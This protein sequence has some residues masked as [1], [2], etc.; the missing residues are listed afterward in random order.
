MNE[1][2]PDAARGAVSLTEVLRAA[3]AEGFRAEFD[4]ETAAAEG[5]PDG[6]RCSDCGGTS[7]AADV[8]RL[9]TRRLEGASDPADMLHV[10]GLRCPRCS[11]LGVLISPYGANIDPA[12]VEILR[13]LPPPVG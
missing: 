10:S 6:L 12:H 9:W 1:T 11:A 7:D 13:R 3:E 4:V 5:E 8:P 2:E